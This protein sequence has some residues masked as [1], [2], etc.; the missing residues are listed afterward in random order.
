MLTVFTKWK[1]EKIKELSTLQQNAKTYA[2]DK[3]ILK[4]AVFLVFSEKQ[5]KIWKKD[6]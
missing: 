3:G 6:I 4:E 1:A 2:L 5:K